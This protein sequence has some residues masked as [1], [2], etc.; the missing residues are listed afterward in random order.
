M[1]YR[2]DVRYIPKETLKLIKR[3]EKISKELIEIDEKLGI[4][5]K[6]N[7]WFEGAER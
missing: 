5:V 6:D 4:W 2:T 3:R 7:I 1:F